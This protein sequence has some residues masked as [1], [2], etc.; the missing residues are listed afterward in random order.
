MLSSLLSFSFSMVCEEVTPLRPLQSSQ[1]DAVAC[2]GVSKM[3][4]SN[5]PVRD[6][7]TCDEGIQSAGGAIKMGNSEI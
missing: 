1:K 6:S 7:L 5:G 3:R 2:R 4:P